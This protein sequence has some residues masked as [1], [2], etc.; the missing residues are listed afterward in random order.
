M[1]DEFVNAYKSKVKDASY[2]CLSETELNELLNY[3]WIYK[4]NNMFEHW[5]VNEFIS[6]ND[7]W[8][9]FKGIRSMNDH[10]YEF[11]IEGIKPNYYA[12]VCRVLEKEKGDGAPL[13]NWNSY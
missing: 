13:L 5:Q 4:K 6:E 11:H 3:L 12:I 2:T 9:E 10:G 7:I 1:N 8:D